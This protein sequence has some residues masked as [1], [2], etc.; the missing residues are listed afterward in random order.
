MFNIQWCKYERE[1]K[2]M[3]SN[4]PLSIMVIHFIFLSIARKF[5]PIPAETALMQW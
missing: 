2:E 1:N 4:L 5:L 3:Y